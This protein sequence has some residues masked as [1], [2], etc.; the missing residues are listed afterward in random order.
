MFTLMY[1]E[2]VME[3]NRKIWQ[4]SPLISYQQKDPPRPRQATH[5]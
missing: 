5:D 3:K 2:S 1:T 4:D